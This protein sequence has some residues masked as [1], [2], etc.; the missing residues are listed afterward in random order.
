MAT[1]AK[2]KISQL[3]QATSASETTYIPV[4]S[5][6]GIVTTYKITPN[7]LVKGT[8]SLASKANLSGGNNISGEQNFLDAINVDGSLNAKADAKI[9]GDIY[10][11]QDKNFVWGAGNLMPISKILFLSGVT[12]DIQGQINSIS[13]TLSAKAN[14]SGATFTGAVTMP[15]ANVATLS[16]SGAATVPSGSASGHA[17]NKGQ[18]DL[19]ANIAGGNT[20][21]GHQTFSNTVDIDGSLDVAQNI[22]CQGNLL[23]STM[24]LSEWLAMP[25]GSNILYNS[26]PIPGEK[27]LNIKNTT[28]DVQV[29]LDG[30]LSK[31]GDEAIAGSLSISGS[32]LA[33]TITTPSINISDTLSIQNSADIEMQPSSNIVVQDA[34]AFNGYFTVPSRNLRE[35]SDWTGSLTIIVT[36]SMTSNGVL[37]IIR[38]TVRTNSD[39]LH[40]FRSGIGTYRLE[41]QGYAPGDYPQFIPTGKVPILM[42]QGSIIMD[43]GS[44]GTIRIS[45]YAPGYI[46][47]E[48][49]LVV[50]S[51]TTGEIA[52]SS[53]ADG[54]LNN[55]L[56]DIKFY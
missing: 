42:N 18:L 51:T 7:D 25:D 15:T 24:E 28:S 35:L 14:L 22:V 23:A 12:S 32:L 44:A 3:Q 34:N 41:M 53:L 1:I 10:I 27:L 36:Q 52:V 40:F 38:D 9:V 43:S 31:A 30:K 49:N 20:F 11:N 21:S 56:L 55:T 26:N 8:Q 17:V 46:E 6:T 13:N 16:V 2:T 19:K 4:S 48:T 39:A 47:F 5:G 45:D 29:Q 33:N 50:A 54:I 37:N